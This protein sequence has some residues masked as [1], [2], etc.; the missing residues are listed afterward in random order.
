MLN[1]GTQVHIDLAVV[2]F[3]HKSIPIFRPDQISSPLTGPLAEG[4][5]A[6]V[7]VI[8]KLQSESH[9]VE[10]LSR[11]SISTQVSLRVEGEFE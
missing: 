11:R 2:S 9:F 10:I 4:S 3:L 8:E 6:R 7:P 5:I 1:L